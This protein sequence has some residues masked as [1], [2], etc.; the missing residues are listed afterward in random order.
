MGL[1]VFR[2]NY[3]AGALLAF[4]AS[5]K[6]AAYTFFIGG[7][8]MKYCEKQALKQN[9]F[10]FVCFSILIPSFGTIMATFIV[11]LLKGTARPLWSTLPTV[12]FGPMAFI[13]WSIKTRYNLDLKQGFG[14]IKKALLKSQFR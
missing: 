13:F 10:L 8:F 6:Q 12:I 14:L 5:A 1:I 2:I 11:H 7:F 4:V 9:L 3:S